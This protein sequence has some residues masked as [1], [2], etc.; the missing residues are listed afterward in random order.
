MNKRAGRVIPAMA[1]ILSALLLLSACGDKPDS[2]QGIMRS[3]SFQVFTRDV[4]PV[5]EARCG[6]GCH[7]VAADGYA[8]YMKDAAHAARFRFP[9]D[10]V[11]GR[12]PRQGE[13]LFA[14]FDISVKH[15]RID[16]AEAARFS[17]LLRA[18][19]TQDYGGLP[20]QGLDVFFTPEETGYRTLERWITLE[21]A[22]RPQAPSE[23]PGHV[24]YFR[25]E[26]QG[27]LVRNGCFLSNCHGPAAF[28]DLKLQPP[29]P[30]EGGDVAG[31]FS[32]AMVL[33]NR[34]ALL[35][36]VTRFAN[37]GGDLRRS[38][39]IVKNL[40]IAEGGIHQRGGNDQFFESFEDRD[41]QILLD[42]LGQE[43][44]A[45]ARQLTS[46]GQAV[47]EAD[48][49]RLQGIV[50][51][52]GSRHAPRRFFDLDAYWPGSDIFLLPLD[53]DGAAGTPVNLTAAFHAEAPVE[54]QSFDV[55]YDGRAVVL[56]M[57]RSVQEGF[58]LYELSLREDGRGAVELRQLSFAPQRR[59]GGGLIHHIDPVYIP[60]PGDPDGHALDVVAIAYA[61]N[62]AGDYAQAQP[63]ALVGEADGGA[64]TE[65]HDRERSER[66][67]S[68][69]GRRIAFVAGPNQGQWRTIKSHV[70]LPGGGANLVLD[71]P[72]PQPLDRRSVYTIEQPVSEIV[73]AYDIWRL[74]PSGDNA[75][76]AFESSARRMT[77]SGAQER[78]P[79]LRTT[80]EV[81]FTSVRNIGYQGGRPVYNGAIF[82]VHAGGFDYH[83]QG[84]N[85]SRHALY[86]DSRETAEGLE[87]RL[88]L[89]P[90]NHWGGA[91]MLADH[92][93]GVNAEP[94]NPMDGLAYSRDDDD[95]IAFSI[96]PR[97]IPSLIPL[98]PE[99]GRHGVTATGLSP[100]GGFRDPY[101]LPDGSLLVAHAAGPLDQLDPAADPDW[102]IY[103]IL[104]PGSPQSLDGRSAGRV[105]LEKVVAASTKL[106]DYHPRPLMLR[107][108]ERPETHQKFI[109]GL[110]EAGLRDDLGVRRAPDGTLAVVE[111]F[112]YPLLQS[113]LT[114][115]TPAG[116]RGLE[117]ADRLFRYVRIIAQ[118]PASREDL[119]PPGDLADPFA[120]RL[121]SG[122]HGRR[123]IVA[124]VPLEAD[125][126]F[127]AEV[128]PNTPLIMQGLD[129]QRRAVHAMNRWFYL[130]PGE[131]LT[132]SIPRS[133]FPHACAGCHGSLTGEQ[134]DA[135]GPPD[136][137][138]AS[139]RVMANWDP[140]ARARRKPFGAGKSSADYRDIDFRRDVQ[141]ILDRACVSC[142]AGV[143]AAAGLDLAPT[144]TR[145]YSVAYESLHRLRDPQSGNFAEKRYID[146]RSA[147]A[148]NSG[149]IRILLEGHPVQ[150]T[151]SEDELL[152]LIR[153]ID[154]GATF[155]GGRS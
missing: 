27:V 50:F 42:W 24:T 117:Q 126:S 49:G 53:A 54:I 72:L 147:L 106:A 56:A 78:R 118:L 79:T 63:W 136:L 21:I 132:F 44:R 4:V 10:P 6:A 48:L 89:D 121:S 76:A 59:G 61:S 138:T 12:I 131:R 133:L 67:G 36:R 17:P 60:G 149:L 134:A 51:I 26:V 64:G 35:G 8:A 90:R 87:V 18:P 5:L 123:V 43:R 73:P 14:T 107:L 3:E 16:Y 41:V 15:G 91:L 55:R 20:H 58:R 95:G 153:W 37:L 84:G 146:E 68:L 98:L 124:E 109:P 127:Y 2:P 83:V 130:Q 92:G 65:L 7:G 105:V 103:R 80:G 114:D 108:K 112:D 152:T 154:L 71:R 23:L 45:L 38:R 151:L 22:R 62:E 144:P 128:P 75:R 97:F 28:N 139:S 82:R 29:L 113:F 30:A 47:A 125:G 110:K 11:S 100:G 143:S 150:K 96:A 52:R 88:A 120:S 116:S 77:W 145:H 31:G 9:I 39:L 74:V 140:L 81:M 135:L 33:E 111:C 141:P 1:A 32:R 70:G 137:V 13:A 94:E 119:A 142:H 66:P 93:L 25:D 40:P 86:A 148:A 19:L 69:D 104:F 34:A 57:R 101:P 129:A 115:F 102:D 46:E 155:I 99:T 122:V 85:R